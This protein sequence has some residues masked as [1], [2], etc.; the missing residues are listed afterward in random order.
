[1]VAGCTK[2]S[3]MGGDMNEMERDLFSLRSIQENSRASGRG[4]T[5]GM[6]GEGR[7]DRE[8]PVTHENRETNRDVNAG[9]MNRTHGTEAA[10][11][12]GIFLV[13]TFIPF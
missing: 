2:C 4:H 1:M 8:P 9:G 11:A 13:L 5:Q 12:Q 3:R 7:G 6:E 10:S